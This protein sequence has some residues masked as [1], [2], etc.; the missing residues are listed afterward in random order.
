MEMLSFINISTDK[1]MMTTMEKLTGRAEEDVLVGL[2]RNKVTFR[3]LTIGAFL[4]A[5]LELF[6]A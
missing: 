6:F 5:A 4:S 3:R 1:W 2:E